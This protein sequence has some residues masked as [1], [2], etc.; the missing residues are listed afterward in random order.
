MEAA[1]N[2]NLPPKLIVF[3]LIRTVLNTAHRMVYPFLSAFARGLGVDLAVLSNVMAARGLI[4]MIG[5]LA[6]SLADRRGRKVGILAGMGLFSAAAA[7]VVAWPTFTGFAA[8]MLL[9]SFGKYIFDISL[10]SWLG[11]RVPYERRGRVLAVT[12]FGW[13]L[14]FI[15]GVPLVG[16]L[17][18]RGGWDSPFLL[19]ASLGAVAFLVLA[20]IIPRDAPTKTPGSRAINKHN[21]N[22]ILHSPAFLP[23]L[24]S[25]SLGLFS[26]AANETVNLIFGVWLEDA[27]GLQIAALGAASAV[28][29]LSELGGEGLVAAFVDRLGKPRAVALGLVV[30]SLAA[31]TLPVLGSTEAGALTGLF[32]FYISFEFT[33]VSSIPLMTEMLP[34]ARA[35][36]LAMNVAGLSLGRALGAF[37]APRLYALGFLAVAAGAVTFNLLALLA[38]WRMKR[39]T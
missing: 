21:L 11:D 38:L 32:F 9:M 5:P 25:L 28:I 13:S 31:L 33:I 1:Q 22:S 10:V 15:L 8:A 27:F 35:T 12:E 17:I 23:I 39:S 20:V 19:F 18:A 30:N 3:T 36:M 7:L 2:S 16:L 26:S 4:G 24:A 14:A 37:A 6:A 34:S 29:G